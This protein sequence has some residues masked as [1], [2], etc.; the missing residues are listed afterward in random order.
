VIAALGRRE[1][2]WYELL[3]HNPIAT[4]LISFLKIS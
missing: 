3:A 2:F 4:S 1:D